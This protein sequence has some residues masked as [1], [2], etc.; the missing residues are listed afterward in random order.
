MV[1]VVGQGQ[2]LRLVAKAFGVSLSTLQYWVGRAGDK[3][4]ASV[5]W[6]GHKS[7]PRHAPHRCSQELEGQVLET[8]Q[9]L[10]E[11]DAL[12]YY[13]ASAIRQALL[14]AG[15]GDV[16][17]ERTINRILERRGA[18]DGQK[19]ASASRPLLLAGIWPMWQGARRSLTCGTGLRAW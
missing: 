11:Q 17:S 15:P 1:R 14:S 7:G 19:S 18:F 16:P 13:G 2:S 9:Y 6:S 4:L 3:P 12:G 5:D 8:R 10:K